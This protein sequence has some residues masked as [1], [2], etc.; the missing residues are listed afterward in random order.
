MR[1]TAYRLAIESGA[2]DVTAWLKRRKAAIL[3]Y[4]GLTPSRPPEPLRPLYKIMVTCDDFRTQMRLLKERF[5]VVPLEELAERIARGDSFERLAAVTFD[6][7]WKTTR[8]LAAPILHELGIPATVFVATGLVGTDVRGLW[9]HRVWMTL[10]STKAT[11]ISIAGVDLPSTN[12]AQRMAAIKAVSEA[13]KRMRSED[14]RRTLEEIERRYG[15]CPELPEDLAFMTWDEVKELPSLGVSVGA[16]TVDHEI[17]TRLDLE[18][19]RDQ[20]RRS[21]LEL[22]RRVGAPCRTFAYPNGSPADFNDDHAR[23]LREEGFLAAVTQVPGRN[24]PLSDCFKLKR[25]NVGLDHTRE[26]FLAEVEGLRHWP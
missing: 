12:L 3:T 14:R 4:H 25:F 26:S 6:D 13:L 15:P 22:E 8:T 5:V 16:H 10:H 23:M 11:R 21:R 9:T 1:S 20:V 18:G 7:G 2:A 17:L 24:A 19:A